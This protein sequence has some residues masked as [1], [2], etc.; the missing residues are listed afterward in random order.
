[1]STSVVRA[2][3]PCG[4]L[5]VAALCACAS[6]SAQPAACD[7]CEDLC[8]L[9]DQLQQK[10]KGIELWRQ[11]AAS[12][13]A[14]QRRPLPP[15]VTDLEGIENQVWN[16]FTQ[17]AKDRKQN[18]ELPC[19]FPPP[20]PGQA[21]PSV[22]VDLTTTVSNDSC[23]ISYKG[24]KLEGQVL[25]DYETDTNCKVS[26]DATIAH[27]ETHREHCMR[28]YHS[29]RANAPKILDTPENVAESELQSWTRHRDVLREGIRAIAG[30]CGWEPTKRQKKDL[31]S[32]PSTQQTKDMQARGWK[33]LNALKGAK[34]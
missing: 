33:A 2:A 15:G 22:A 17:W 11:Y 21:P 26:S 13:P 30:R 24:K 18:D 27:E 19:K 9:V 23:E 32:V 1:M 6:A 3:L 34:P 12:T 10:E 31:E 20:P 25:K 16:E 29:D 7:K 8:R 4:A 14:S 28:A 5:L